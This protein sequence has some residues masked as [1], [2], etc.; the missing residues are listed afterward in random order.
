MNKHLQLMQYIKHWGIGS[1]ASIMARI[2]L[3]FSVY[4]RSTLSPMFHFTGMSNKI[5]Q[6]V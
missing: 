6:P 1:L 3:Y 4:E 2:N 5:L